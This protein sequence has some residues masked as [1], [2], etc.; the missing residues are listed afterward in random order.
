MSFSGITHRS[1]RIWSGLAW[2]GIG[3]L[4][5]NGCESNS[6]PET[7]AAE[8]A[9][10]ETAATETAVAE[11]AV[12]KPSAPA[13]EVMEVTQDNFN[14]QVLNSPLP[15][16][17]DFWAPWCGPCRQMAPVV[18]ELAQ[19][20]EGKVRMV[21]VDVDQNPELAQKYVGNQGIP[22][23]LIFKKGE[24]VGYAS[25]IGPGTKRAVTEFLN[26]LDQLPE[27]KKGEAETPT[28]DKSSEDKNSEDKNSDAKPSEDKTNSEKSSEAK[29]SEDKPS[30]AKATGDNV[31]SDKANDEKPPEDKAASKDKM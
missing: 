26:S 17:I 20:F 8:T 11:A 24:P 10:A 29:S 19:Q 31:T 18:E 22:L 13:V 23:L 14:A 16:L 28:E 1:L 2:C 21:K 7:A 6:K 4:A 25:G 9:A 27:K 12:K 30:D 15:V 5:F 3:L